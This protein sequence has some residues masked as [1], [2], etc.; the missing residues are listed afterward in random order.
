MPT[1]ARYSYETPIAEEHLGPGQT[2]AVPASG[3]LYVA[4][5]PD[6]TAAVIVPPAVRTLADL[7][8]VPVIHSTQ[9]STQ[10]VLRLADGFRLWAHAR[11]PGDVLSTMRQKAVLHAIV[12]ETFRLIG[13]DAWAR[14]ERSVVG[15]SRSLSELARLVSQRREDTAFLRALEAEL[16]EFILGDSKDRVQRLTA[17]VQRWRLVTA[18]PPRQSGGTTALGRPDGADDAG[19]LIELALRLASDP[20]SLNLRD[21]DL[22]MRILRLLDAPILAR[23]ARLVVIVVD[24]AQASRTPPGEAYA[25]WSWT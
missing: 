13:G 17:L 5:R 8:C 6:F 16:G 20:A 19:S 21:N 7:G 2:H 10:S 22:Q 1:L 25:G 12:T 11:M 3:G 4:Q 14:A 18:G 15:T 24:R 23:A 9:R